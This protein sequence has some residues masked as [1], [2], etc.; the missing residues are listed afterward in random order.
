[1]LL[2]LLKTKMTSLFCLFWPKPFSIACRQ[3]GVLS[4]ALVVCLNIYSKP[5]LCNEQKL[6]FTLSHHLPFQQCS[7]LSGNVS[8]ELDFNHSLKSLKRIKG[9]TTDCN[10]F[11]PI[12]FFRH[13]Q[14]NKNNYEACFLLEFLNYRYVDE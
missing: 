13:L 4:H 6:K 9:Y 12:T 14:Q 1:M 10:N 3:P 8:F 5:R 7:I 11:R 2:F